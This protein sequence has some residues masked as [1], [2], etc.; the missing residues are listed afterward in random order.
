M[1]KKYYAIAARDG[2]GIYDDYQKVIR[3]K[4]CLENK[5]N[6]VVTI[7]TCKNMDEARQVAIHNYNFFQEEEKSQLLLDYRLM[8][9]RVL[10]RREIKEGKCQ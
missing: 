10:F 6:E 9:N 5:K 8:L 7:F 1:N 3:I 2:V 4:K